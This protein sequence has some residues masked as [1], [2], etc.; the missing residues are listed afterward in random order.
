MVCILP[1][2]TYLTL[3]KVRC[4]KFTFKVGGTE[5]SKLLTLLL[6]TVGLWA[7]TQGCWPPDLANPVFS[8]VRTGC[9]NFPRGRKFV[10]VRW[11]H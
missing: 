10:G 9:R 3:G 4:L 2:G 11:I 6:Y 7:F 8:G 1:T 5:M